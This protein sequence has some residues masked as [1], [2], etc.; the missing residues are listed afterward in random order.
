MKNLTLDFDKKLLYD[1]MSWQAGKQISPEL[2]ITKLRDFRPK[3]IRFE[4]LTVFTWCFD[5]EIVI[6]YVECMGDYMPA[7]MEDMP[8]LRIR[9]AEFVGLLRLKEKELEELNKG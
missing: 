4:G 8:G 7:V 9:F 2:N 5:E 1:D 6:G 3:D